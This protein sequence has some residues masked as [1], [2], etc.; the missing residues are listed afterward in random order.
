MAEIVQTIAAE[1][2]LQPQISPDP[3]ATAI[4][5]PAQTEESGQNLLTRLGRRTGAVITPKDQRLLVT[6]RHSGKAAS[7]Q[8]LSITPD[9]LTA[10]RGYSVRLKPRTRHSEIR[11]RWRDRPAG[12]TKTVTLKTGLEGPSMTLREVCQSETEAQKA[13]DAAK[14]DMV[15]GEGEVELMLVGQPLPRAEAPVRLQTSVWIW[16]AHGSPLRPPHEW[17]FNGGAARTIIRA[18]F[19][20]DKDEK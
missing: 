11:A 9:M 19:G 8:P 14:R 20:A 5:F 16:M 3:G 6:A 15:A 17:A 2:N 1:H 18:E 13:A 4:P 7:G 12:R 10:D